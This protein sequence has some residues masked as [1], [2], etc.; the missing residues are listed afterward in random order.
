M[1]LLT[2]CASPPLVLFVKD[3]VSRLCTTLQKIT[4]ESQLTVL[5]LLPLIPFIGLLCL[6]LYDV[7]KSRHSDVSP[8]ANEAFVNQGA[9]ISDE[10]QS[11]ELDPF[12][13]GSWES[14]YYQYKKWH[15]PHVF[16]LEFDPATGKVNG[17]GRDG[18]GSFSI[19]GVYLGRT[20]RMALTKKYQQGTGDR[21]E[22]FGHSVTIHLQWNASRTKFDGDWY[23]RTSS[24]NRTDR[25]ELQFKA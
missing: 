22:N 15:G 2:Y 13:T 24:Y 11:Q 1:K 18:V 19:D 23:V 21:S 14:R 20:G 25:F 10:N 17:D 4:S 5:N 12:R 8:S 3:Y 7:Y 16:S 6:L 9:D